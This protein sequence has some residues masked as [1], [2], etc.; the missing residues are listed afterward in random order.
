MKKAEFFCNYPDRVDDNTRSAIFNSCA[1]DLPDPSIG[2]H[3]CVLENIR[4]WLDQFAVPHK[5][6]FMIWTFNGVRNFFYTLEIAV[7]ALAKLYTAE[8]GLKVTHSFDLSGFA[9]SKA[10]K[11]IVA[12]ILPL[13]PLASE[14]NEECTAGL[15]KHASLWLSDPALRRQV[16]QA[17]RCYVRLKK[18]GMPST[19]T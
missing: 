5:K 6:H 17:L 10:G 12:A 3:A 15:G 8:T 2:Q 9:A 19:E 18:R 13:R 11:F 14:L 4:A 16:A 7:D 1:G